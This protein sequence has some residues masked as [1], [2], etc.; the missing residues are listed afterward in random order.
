M[1]QYDSTTSFTSYHTCCYCT[2]QYG[3]I[4]YYITIILYCIMIY[5]L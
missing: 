4:H 3:M 1:I 2:V 5:D